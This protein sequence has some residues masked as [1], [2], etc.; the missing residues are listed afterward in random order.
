[1]TNDYIL[2]AGIAVDFFTQIQ[3]FSFGQRMKRIISG[4]IG[5]RWDLLSFILGLRGNSEIL[6]F[7]EFSSL[8]AFW[9]CPTASFNARI[10]G[11]SIVDVDIEFGA[12]D[13]EKWRPLFAVRNS[14]ISIICRTNDKSNSNSR[15]TSLSQQQSPT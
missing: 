15:R 11:Y 10:R 13:F 2:F 3:S 12:L 4:T 14:M 6:Y 8:F 7:W 9:L 1:M 5:I